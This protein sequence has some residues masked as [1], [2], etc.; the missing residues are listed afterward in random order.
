[1]TKK[2]QEGVIIAEKNAR[3]SSSQGLFWSD[4]VFIEYSNLQDSVLRNLKY[5]YQG[6]ITNTRTGDIIDKAVEDYNPP[7]E[8]D[9]S[10]SIWHI[11]RPTSDA[12]F[13]LLG[14]QNGRGEVH[15]LI[16][17]PKSFPQK[18]ILGVYVRLGQHSMKFELGD[19]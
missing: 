2:K 18:T 3:D 19:A 8:Q 16:D 6:T 11:F 1:M 12:F 7:T 9:C 10:G 14:N 13:A 17:H 5:I 15:L 4:I